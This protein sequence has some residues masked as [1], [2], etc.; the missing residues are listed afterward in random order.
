M[1]IL[2]LNTHSL[3][4]ENYW[5]KLAC[6]LDI[7]VRERPDIVAL[8]EVNQTISAPLIDPVRL[9]NMVPVP[10][11]EIPVRWDNH[12]A[13]VAYRLGRAGVPCSWTWLPIKVGYGKY[14]E[15]VALLS[16]SGKITQVDSFRISRSDNYHNWKT[17]KVLGVRIEG[18]E[19][20][21]YTAHMGW[22]GDEDEPFLM[23]WGRLDTRLAEKK[24]LAP[25][26]LL[27]DFNSPAEV[28]NE[29]YDCIRKFGWQDTYLLADKKD[30]GITVEGVIDGWRDKLDPSAKANGM[31]IDHIWCSQTVPIRRSHVKFNGKNGP[32]VSDH[33]GVLVE[34]GPEEESSLK[35]VCNL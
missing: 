29:G 32:Q 35:E 7:I 28:R 21:F 13:E 25:V 26:W 14:D 10:G 8:Q 19:D 22:W 27:G 24:E 11:N 30:S 6:F 4:E 15:G 3:Q 17:R 33:F 12:A 9:N 34:T 16:L 5:L 31:R 18:R 1:K 23:Q 2:T 20:W